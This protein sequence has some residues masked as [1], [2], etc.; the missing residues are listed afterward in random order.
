[1]QIKYMVPTLLLKIRYFVAL[2]SYSDIASD[3]LKKL[4]SSLFVVEC[5]TEGRAA[6]YK[7]R[8][9]FNDP[10]SMRNILVLEQCGL[11][12]PPATVKRPVM[13]FKGL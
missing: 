4:K 13:V 5:F 6:Q 10:A 12:L 8:K 3:T 11:T 2:S 1:M 9:L 7:N